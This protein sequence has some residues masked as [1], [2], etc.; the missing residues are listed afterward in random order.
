MAGQDLPEFALIMRG[1]DRQQV[2]DYVSTLRGYVDELSRRL[3]EQGCGQ[4][5]VRPDDAPTDVVVDPVSLLGD[6]VTAILRAGRDAADGM[7]QDALQ[8]AEQILAR[9]KTGSQDAEALIAAARAVADKILAAARAEAEALLERARSH[10]EQQATELLQEA[11]QEAE[12]TREQA[13]TQATQAL[14][15]LR[16][17]LTVPD[18]AS[19]PLP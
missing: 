13:H 4:E 8:E 9:A 7:R 17:H 5:H 15:A 12:R 18:G 10:A 16:E 6:R 3:D 1:Y 2:D 14:Q 11:E 19:A